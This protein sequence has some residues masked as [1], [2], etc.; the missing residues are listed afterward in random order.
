MNTA[1]K[2]IDPNIFAGRVIVSKRA[3]VNSDMQCSILMARIKRFANVKNT[4]N[5]IVAV[6]INPDEQYANS[7][8]T[9]TSKSTAR[10]FHMC[11]HMI[12]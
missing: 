8:I 2:Q 3:W 5:M 10:P 12:L 4:T 11:P 7:H 6:V 9:I 1:S